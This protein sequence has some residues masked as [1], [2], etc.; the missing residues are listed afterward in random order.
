MIFVSYE[1]PT[2][3]KHGTKAKQPIVLKQI[4]EKTLNVIKESKIMKG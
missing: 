1:F 2:Q 4:D 3:R